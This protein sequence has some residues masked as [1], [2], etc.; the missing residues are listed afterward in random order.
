MNFGA[1]SGIRAAARPESGSAATTTFR[2]AYRPP[3]DWP[4]VLAFLAA[5]RVDGIESVD[6][7]CYSRSV[8]WSAGAQQSVGWL[9]LR[10]PPDDAPAVEVELSNDLLHV[11]QPILQR[12]RDTLDLERDCAPILRALPEGTRMHGPMRLVGSFDGFELAVRGVVGQQ[13]S[14]KAA[15]TVVAR[16]AARFGRP[17]R[18][19]PAGLDRVFPDAETIAAATHDEIAAMGMNRRRAATIHAIAR[20]IVEGA[21]QLEPQAPVEET[22]DALRSIPG[23]GDWT[24]QYIAMRALCWTDAFP[25][26]DL[27]VLRALDVATAAQARARADAWRPWRAYAVMN[28]WASA[29]IAA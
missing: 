12:L 20:R 26:A 4:K 17:L 6:A 21:L 11:A 16:F 22:I 5:R 24:A 13:I 14:V 19:G 10:A 2:L 23:I 29:T 9:C 27:A 18:D 25:A 28:L 8:L 7:T 3:Y 15:R 1:A